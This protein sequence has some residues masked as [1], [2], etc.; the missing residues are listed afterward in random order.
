MR[1]RMLQADRIP[2]WILQI[3]LLHPVVGDRGRLRG[4]VVLAQVSV[5]GVG[6]QVD[7][8]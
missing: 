3:Q 7:G 2:I 4:D 8:V 5:R 6:Q 1:I